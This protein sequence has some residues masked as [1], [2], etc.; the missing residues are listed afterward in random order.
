MNN[1]QPFPATLAA[2]WLLSAALFA[3]FFCFTAVT[4]LRAEN[5]DKC[6]ERVEQKERDLHRAIDRHGRHSKQA[7]H[8]RRELHAQRERCWEEFQQWWDDHEHR[9]HHDRDWDDHDHDRD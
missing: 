9:W 5:P 3:A 8:E 6:K 4:Q 7:D 2:K 1:T